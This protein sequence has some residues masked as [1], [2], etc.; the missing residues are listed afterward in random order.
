MLRY[1]WKSLIY[2]LQ[3]DQWKDYDNRLFTIFI[4]YIIVCG[5]GA[6]IIIPLMLI[7]L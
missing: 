1:K 5:I 4:K 7:L 3:K 6:H 2:N